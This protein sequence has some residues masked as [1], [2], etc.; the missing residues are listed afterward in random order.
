MI[1]MRDSTL[2]PAWLQAALAASPFK[3]TEVA[4]SFFSCPVRCAFVHVMAPNP[5]AKNDDGTP[6]TNPLYEVTG[7][8]PDGG[9]ASMDAVIWPAVY[10]M[11]KAEFGAN[12]NAQT[13]QPFGLHNPL[14]RMQDEKAQQFKGYTPGLPFIRLTSQ[15]RPTVVDSAGN[16]IVDPARVYPGVWAVLRFNRYTFGKSPPRPKKGISLGLEA[17]MLV[18]D[19]S[20]LGGGAID[21]KVAFTGVQ[22]NAH[23]DPARAFAGSAAP[24]AP[25]PPPG[26]SVMPPPMSV[27]NTY[28]P[29]PPP[30]PAAPA[31]DMNSMLG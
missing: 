16:P 17:V 11:M 8:I 19:D 28:A 12:I 22:I 31:F 30:A 1:P 13:G 2:P 7:L 10:N 26:N 14:L 21:P 4:G 5:N 15:Y 20:P 23:F 25:P 9:K 24:G 6:K 3:P 27:A 29:P 18:A